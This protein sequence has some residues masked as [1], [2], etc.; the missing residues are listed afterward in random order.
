MQKSFAP[1]L[2]LVIACDYSPAPPVTAPT[3][4]AAAQS[5]TTF[6]PEGSILAEV[7]RIIDGDTICIQHD[8]KEQSIRIDGIDCPETRGDGGQLY[9]DK[10]ESFVSDYRR[11]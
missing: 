10:A 11:H 4:T 7:T 8:G 5:V 6:A 2:L 1:L 9:G 3:S